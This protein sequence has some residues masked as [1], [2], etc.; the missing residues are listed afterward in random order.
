MSKN[1]GLKIPVRA[2]MYARM[3]ARAYDCGQIGIRTHDHDRHT[4]GTHDQR[5]REER[6][7]T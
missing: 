2:R 5:T 1:Y 6:G 3:F 7:Q 4:N